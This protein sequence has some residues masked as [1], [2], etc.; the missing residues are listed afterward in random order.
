MTNATLTIRV[1]VAVHNHLKQQ[2][3]E[4]NMSLQAMCYMRIMSED[5][6]PKVRCYECGRQNDYCKC[7]PS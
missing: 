4:K 5:A 1:P 7:T 2:A 6:M 3:W